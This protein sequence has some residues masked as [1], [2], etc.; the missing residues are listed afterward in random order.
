MV[1]PLYGRFFAAERISTPHLRITIGLVFPSC[2]VV[3]QIKETKLAFFESE[4]AAKEGRR[5]HKEC[6]K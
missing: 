6:P 5:L 4:E 3:A 2:S 1:W